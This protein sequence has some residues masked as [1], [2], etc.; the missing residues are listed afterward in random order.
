MN[1]RETLDFLFSQLPMYQRIGAAAYK[2]DLDTTWKLLEVLGN[3]QNTSTKFIHVAGT[4][5]KGSV[6]HMIASVLQEAGFTTG[7]FTS[8]HLKDF[9]ERIRINGISISEEE[10]IDFVE[11]NESVF[12][13]I[14]PSFFEMTAAL[15]LLC[16]KKRQTDFAILETGMGGRLDST[17]VVIPEVSVITNIGLDHTRFLGNSIEEIAAEKA[18]II[19][20]GRP[21]VA[22]KMRRE[23]LEVIERRA[24]EME[25]AFH[26][27]E[28]VQEQEFT[29]DL[30]GIYQ[31]ENVGTAVTVLKVLRKQG[32]H[33]ADEHIVSGLQNVVRNTHLRGRWQVLRTAPTTICDV[34][35]NLDGMTMV[36]QQLKATPHNHLHFVIGMVDDKD[37]SEILGILP[38]NATYYFCAA[39]IPRA[40]S[41]HK[42]QSAALSKGLNGKTYPSV[43]SAFSTAISA[44]GPKDL[45]FVGGSV[46]V[47]AEVL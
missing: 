46:F 41:P 40:L 13:E 36:V 39:D 21:V 2:A 45:V 42:L 11:E 33:I 15:A 37:L 5:G 7:L 27:S 34:G 3:P 12:E 25:A 1:Y 32:F 8:P 19:K 47:V 16:F 44:A 24:Q 17:N 30:K 22:G 10:V 4:N 20:S 26:T 28:N 6:S 43:G 9:R 14:K 29:T 38:E 31:K 35:H 23:A 18:G